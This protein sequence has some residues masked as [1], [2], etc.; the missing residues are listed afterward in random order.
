MQELNYE[1]VHGDP[2][3]SGRVPRSYENAVLNLEQRVAMLEERARQT[4]ARMDIP[5][6]A[7]ITGEQAA[8]FRR[9][10]EEA[11]RQPDA[12]RHHVL[13]QPPP[14]TPE[15][16][17]YLLRECVTVVKPG[18]VLILRCPEDWT[19]TQVAEMQEHASYWLEENAPDIRV[20]VVPHLEMAVAE[21]EPDAE[22]I[23]RIERLW[24]E[25]RRRQ[26]A[27]EYGNRMRLPRSAL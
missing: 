20:A 3:P 27:R 10:F 9:Q 17:R 12:Y 23:G 24:P 13:V 26:Q 1:G 16:V 14:L 21:P 4:A 8:E 7:P 22:F 25:L 2:V 19:P 15:Q 6:D 11:M 5:A 18:E